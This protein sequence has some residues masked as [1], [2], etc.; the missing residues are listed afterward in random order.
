MQIRAICKP[1]NVWTIFHANNAQD[2][3]NQI[4]IGAIFF[5]LNQGIY[6][7]SGVSL[8]SYA[9]FVLSLNLNITSSEK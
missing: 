9:G 3:D 8:G 6:R 2:I 4:N 5:F 1:H 7:L